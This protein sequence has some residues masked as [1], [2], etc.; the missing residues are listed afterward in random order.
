[1]VEYVL[2]VSFAIVLG[3]I[4]YSVIKTYVPQDKLACPDEVSII[5]KEYTYDCATN[6]LTINLENNGNFNLGGYFI[7]ATITP[8]AT[9][10]TKDLSKNHTDPTYQAL[11][12]IVKFDGNENSFTPGKEEI[13]EYNLTGVGQIYSIEV[14]PIRWQIEKNKKVL[15]SCQNAKIKK[16][17][18]CN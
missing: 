18:E 2:L 1:M 5:L 7:Y 12:P 16:T 17:I 14:L 6:I 11:R 15:A 8:Q 13:D 4:T 9:L 10:A 3:I